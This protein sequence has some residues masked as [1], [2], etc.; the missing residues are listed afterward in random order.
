VTIESKEIHPAVDVVIPVYGERE[1]ALTATLSA[2]VEQ[3]YPVNR[4]F[5][6]DDG[7]PQAVC[8]PV[9]AQVSPQ[10]SLLRLSENQ[11]ISAARNAAIAHSNAPL[12]ACVNT[13]VL[14][15][16]DWL[17]TCAKHLLSQPR[18][19]ACYTRI[20]SIHPHRLLTRWR[21]RFQ[22]SKYGDRTKITPFAHGHA[23]LFRRE[24]IEAVGGYDPRLRLQ[25]EDSD[26]CFRMRDVGWETLYIAE[27][28]CISTQEDYLGQLV[29]KVLREAGW[30]SPSE[31]SLARL[32]F[33]HTKW[34]LVRAGRNV[35]K[36]RLYF[37]PVDAA[38]WARGLWTATSRTLRSSRPRAG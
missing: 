13:E 20:V 9:W 38:I 14:P 29:G 36:G 33:Y 16:P 6:I 32:Y 26:I 18:L 24:A 27:S 25:H 30:Y 12:L 23:V 7:S 4:I 35:V 31:S 28:R 2:C 19:G 3:T 10:V 5:V 22:E 15:D 1:Q 37:L 21:M 8:L 34:T 11:G 17:A